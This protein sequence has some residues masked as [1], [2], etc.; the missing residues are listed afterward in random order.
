MVL[1]ALGCCRSCLDHFVSHHRGFYV[2]VPVPVTVTVRCR[3]KLAVAVENRH[4]DIEKLV[5]QA[6]VEGKLLF[7]SADSIATKTF[8]FRLPSDAGAT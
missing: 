2:R 8:V 6:L 3:N 1:C 5:C 7:D 4:S